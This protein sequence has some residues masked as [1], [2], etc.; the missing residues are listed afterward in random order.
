MGQAVVDES[1]V[2]KTLHVSVAAAADD[3]NTGT[4]SKPLRSIQKAVD[5]AGNEPTRILVH[6]GTYREYVRI[7]AGSSLLIL[8]ATE[9]GRAIISGADPVSDWTAHGNG[10][11][12]FPWKNRWG[13]N[14][15]QFFFP[16]NRT[17]LNLR[18]EMVFVDDQRL[19]QR[20]NED[21]TGSGIAPQALTPGE[22]T[23]S[24]SE[25]KIYF[26]PPPGVA[27]N[28]ASRVE[29][30][31]R[32]YGEK[33]YPFDGK[34]LVLAEERS[35]L[36]LRGM[37]IV[38]SANYILANP[39]FTYRSEAGKDPASWPAN[40]LIDHC[41]FDDHNGVGLGLNTVRNV[42]ILNCSFSGNGER[43]AGAGGIQNL[44]IRDTQLI[45]NGWRFGPWLVGHDMAGL[46]LFD[47]AETDSWFKCR[48]K[49]IRLIRCVFRG[50]QCH[51]FWQD[52]GPT[53][54]VVDSCLFEDSPYT[55]MF[56]EVTS[57]PL[58]L[59]NCVIRRCGL[60]GDAAVLVVASPDVTLTGCTIYDC[61]SEKSKTSTLISL[62]GDKRATDPKME[63]A[64]RRMRIENCVL[65]ANRTNSYLFRSGTWNGAEEPRKD[66][67]ETVLADSNT[68]FCADRPAEGLDEYRTGKTS[69]F[70]N[71]LYGG[72]DKWKSG[73]PDL[74]L[75]QWQKATCNV[76]GP[77]DQHSRWQAVPPETLDK[78]VWPAA[79]E[80][81]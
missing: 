52:F 42:S 33:P 64:V 16:G 51:S 43:G 79:P 72:N 29:V 63:N 67:A 7:R 54:T 40:V 53:D 55:A 11:F 44:L 74:T 32:G 18:R 48:S 15:E 49:N 66:F 39:A 30:A 6:P 31:V 38:R 12:A 68:Y 59:K 21:K 69:F 56:Q 1:A 3:A 37:R 70:R 65:Q 27:L 50:N 46:K 36:V 77:Q 71:T 2:R 58:T 4:D 73:F 28:Q 25:E 13:L 10:V 61:G 8:E 20:C 22:F 19:R 60:A 34:P 24:E 26:R 78:R 5:L 41:A 80:T 14:G 45:G 76:H 17:R 9:P 57:G 23:V 35:N 62:L 81:N 75:E 47:G